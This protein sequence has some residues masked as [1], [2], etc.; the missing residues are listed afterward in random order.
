[1]ASYAVNEPGVERARRLID[2]R[3]DRTSA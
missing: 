2:A 1:M 3:H